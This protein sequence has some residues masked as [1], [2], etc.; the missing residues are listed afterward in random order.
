[1]VFCIW[2]VNFFCKGF[3]CPDATR[4]TLWKD[5]IP[6]PLV[7]EGEF[8][9]NHVLKSWKLFFFNFLALNL[10]RMQL[11]VTWMLPESHD[12]SLDSV[13]KYKFLIHNMEQASHN[14]RMVIPLLDLNQITN[15]WLSLCGFSQCSSRL[16][17]WSSSQPS[18]P[19]CAHWSLWS[20]K[21]T[22]KLRAELLRIK[23]R[24]CDLGQA[25]LFL[26][27]VCTKRKR[28]DLCLTGRF[29]TVSNL[30]HLIYEESYWA[31]S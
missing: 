10:F 16:S 7:P 29:F 9:R 13:W 20:L 4:S 11:N 25:D 17:S 27:C 14:T 3:F 5:P 15:T 1:M 31:M 28:I 23:S 26:F 21:M 6:L 18:C 22:S 19:W 24:R 2:S 30:Y 8:L 12:E